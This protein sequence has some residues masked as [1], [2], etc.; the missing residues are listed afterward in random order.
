VILSIIAK[1]GGNSF[2]LGT[3]EMCMKKSFE[4]PALV[5]HGFWGG[6]V[7]AMVW[8]MVLSSGFGW[9]SA[10]AAKQI[11][12][13]QAQTAVVAYATP[14]CMARFEQQPNSV[15]AWKA[16][17]KQDQD[18]SW[19]DSTYIE[20]GKWVTEPG[21]KLDSYIKDAIADNCASQL[22][23]LKTLD[24]ATLVAK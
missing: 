11:A 1:L 6:V 15:A 24:G 14:V 16:L 18:S 2:P 23:K 13:Q 3:E 10:G 9:M 19:Q 17:Y 21:Q 12:A 5:K 8:W 4:I 22:L 7:G 20:K